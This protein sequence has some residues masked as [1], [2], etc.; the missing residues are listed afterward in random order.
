MAKR[1]KEHNTGSRGW[2]S[3]AMNH[4]RLGE[5]DGR[6][7]WRQR[8]PQYSSPQPRTPFKLTRKDRLAAGI[9]WSLGTVF[10]LGLTMI[11]AFST[12]EA[13]RYG[14]AALM[15]LTGLLISA[16]MARMAIDDFRK[17]R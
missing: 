7:G 1:K 9:L 5:V 6:G 11:A 13:A 4:R 12:I 15:L 10:I 2:L 3:E 8:D 14:R 17:S 16:G